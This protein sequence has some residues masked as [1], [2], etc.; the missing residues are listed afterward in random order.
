MH[1]TLTQLANDKSLRNA[2]LQ[3]KFTFRDENGIFELDF[4]TLSFLKLHREVFDKLYALGGDRLMKKLLAEKKTCLTENPHAAQ[5]GVR[6]ISG[7]NKY[8]LKTNAGKPTTFSSIVH[9]M[10]GF[11]A[12]SKEFDADQVLFL[13]EEDLTADADFEEICEDAFFSLVDFEDTDQPETEEPRWQ[14]EQ[15]L[16]SFPAP[17]QF[18]QNCTL[19]SKGGKLCFYDEEKEQFITLQYTEEIDFFDRNV[20]EDTPKTVVLDNLAACE[21][22]KTEE[23]ELLG[24]RYQ[25]E[26]GGNWGFISRY[27]GQILAPVFEEITVCQST[28]ELPFLLA[29]Q[30]QE[31]YS[32]NHFDLFLSADAVHTDSGCTDLW[33][34]LHPDFYEV[35]RTED[36]RI[37]TAQDENGNTAVLYI[38][39]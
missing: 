14:T 32:E 19:A 10:A 12:F 24:Y 35:T 29:Y 6:P 21:P 4:E 39:R 15:G 22:L 34:P 3:D 7:T 20:P 36:F 33:F 26:E 17:A 8:F 27:C 30:K 13:T 2:L 18:Y 38:F 31:E 5:Q 1:Y 16:F 37:E 11:A 25:T 28:E 23:G 9:G